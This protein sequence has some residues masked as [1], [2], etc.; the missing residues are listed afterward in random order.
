MLS[1]IILIILLGS[2]FIGQRRGFILQLIHLVGF[3]VSIFVA[4]KYYD[5]LASYIRLWI[6]YPQFSS[7]NTFGLIVSAFDAESVYYGGIAFAILFFGTKIALHIVGS[8]LDFVAHLPILRM[9]NRWLGSLLCMVEAYLIMFVLLNVAALIQVEVVQELLHSSVV[10]Q[11]M[12]HNTPFLS[13]WIRELW[14]ST[15]L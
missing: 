6:P 12:I 7:D 11:S 1:F 15:E 14:V 5:V 9:L 10:A 3:F 13:E 2:F 8:M 4:Y